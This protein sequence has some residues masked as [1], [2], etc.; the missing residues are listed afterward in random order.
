[1]C[2]VKDRKVSYFDLNSIT[3]KNALLFLILK[4]EIYCSVGQKISG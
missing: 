1:M 4:Q 2:T 3:F